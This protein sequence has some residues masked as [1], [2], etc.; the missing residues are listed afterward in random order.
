M[1]VC[2]KICPHAVESIAFFSVQ[3]NCKERIG[4]RDTKIYVFDL[5]ENNRLVRHFVWSKFSKN[6]NLYR[7]SVQVC[8]KKI[9][10]YKINENF[11]KHND[12]NFKNEFFTAS[13]IHN[14]RNR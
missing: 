1:F 13:F 10:V 9:K 6:C 11:N 3:Q 8:C 14:D 12:R 4:K 2:S 5:G 7:W